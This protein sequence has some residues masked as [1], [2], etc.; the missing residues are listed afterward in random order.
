[1]K[2]KVIFIVSLAN[3]TRCVSPS[4]IAAS[5]FLRVA[6]AVAVVT[7]SASSAR[8]LN[9]Q[10]LA[11]PI[12][13]PPDDAS[14]VGPTLTGY[15]FG[16]VLAYNPSYAA[17]PDNSG[18]ALFRTGTHVDLDFVGKALTFAYDANVFTDRDDGSGLRPSEDDHIVGLVSR[19]GDLE[20]GAHYETDRSTDRPGQAQSYADVHARAYFDLGRLVPALGL[21]RHRVSGFF[22]LAGFA[23]NPSYAARPDLSGLALLRVVGHTDVD[24]IAARLTL[25]VDLNVFTDRT[26]HAGLVPSELDTTIGLA[27]HLGSFDVSIVAE[28]DRP[29]DRG[30]LSQS[31]VSTLLAYRFDMR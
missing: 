16:G 1:M 29:L 28:N 17:R 8:A 20:L 11:A 9:K 24:L 3:D 22:T 23:Y 26:T 30:G 2:M 12:D 15:V 14:D 7:L 4:R 31:Y 21:P 27:L 5:R 18:R 25:S 13:P 19:H 10:G 6:C